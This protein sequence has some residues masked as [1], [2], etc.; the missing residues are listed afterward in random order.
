ML[1]NMET[2]EKK[3]YKA[4]RDKLL[5]KIDNKSYMMKTILDGL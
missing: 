5:K 1:N 2:L 3:I 4:Y